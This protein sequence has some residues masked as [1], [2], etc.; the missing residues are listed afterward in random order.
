MKIMSAFPFVVLTEVT[1]DNYL[2][3]YSGNTKKEY[4]LLVEADLANYYR[5]MLVDLPADEDVYFEFD[6]QTETIK[7]L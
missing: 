6:E 2:V 7:N 5:E 1:Q 4:R 3:V